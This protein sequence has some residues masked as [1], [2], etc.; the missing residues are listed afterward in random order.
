MKPCGSYVEMKT[1][2]QACCEVEEPAHHEIR[3]NGK[4]Y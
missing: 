3:T 1:R 4:N 2:G